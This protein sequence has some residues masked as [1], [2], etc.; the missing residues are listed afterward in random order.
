MIII[1]KKKQKKLQQQC[2]TKIR[3]NQPEN[4]I[5]CGTCFDQNQRILYESD[6]DYVS[7]III[8]MILR[9]MNIIKKKEMKKN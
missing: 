3:M 7:M 9:M 5:F 1:K 6:S 2:L 8:I 4:T